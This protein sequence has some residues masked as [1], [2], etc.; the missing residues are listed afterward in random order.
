MP[1]ASEQALIGG[2]E[3]PVPN[4][5]VNQGMGLPPNDMPIYNDMIQNVRG[6]NPATENNPFRPNPY[7]AQPS[8]PRL[9]FTETQRRKLYGRKILHKR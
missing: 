5:F 1:L 6:D 8:D 7:T 4:N 2:G 3:S 9:N